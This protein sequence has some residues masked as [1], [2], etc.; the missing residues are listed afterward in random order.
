MGRVDG[1]MLAPMASQVRMEYA[2]AACHVMARRNQGRAIFGDN[3]DRR[4][5]LGTLGQAC[6]KT[7]WRVHALVLLAKGM[8]NKQV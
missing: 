5:W 7:G 1:A 2:G 8:A 6:E 4:A 3:L